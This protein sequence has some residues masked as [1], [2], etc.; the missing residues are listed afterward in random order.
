MALLNSHKKAFISVEQIRILR[1]LSSWS[2]LH[3]TAECHRRRV[4]METPLMNADQKG[5]P[6]FCP[7]GCHLLKYFGIYV[8]GRLLCLGTGLRSWGW[9][10]PGGL[11]HNLGKSWKGWMQLAVSVVC[12][13]CEGL[14]SSTIGVSV[15]VMRSQSRGVRE[16]FAEG[17]AFSW[18]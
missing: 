1:K 17:L 8:F 4:W 6:D 2:F 5:K 9:G 3:S 13:V 15:G 16:G 14:P 12:G 10:V 11:T 18:A 7:F